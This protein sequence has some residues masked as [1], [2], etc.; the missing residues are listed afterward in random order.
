MMGHATSMANRAREALAT[1]GTASV[2]E[3][4]D[5]LGE[6][7]LRPVGQALGA[8]A[9]KHNRVVRVRPGVYQWVGET[10]PTTKPTTRTPDACPI[11]GC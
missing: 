4:A 7:D 11:L 10:K 5:I 9:R 8:E 1:L 6:K 2:H 3:I